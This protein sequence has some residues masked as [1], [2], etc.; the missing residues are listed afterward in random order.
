MPI[1]RMGNSANLNNGQP[2]PGNHITEAALPDGWD[3]EERWFNAIVDPQGIWR[4]HSG[5]S[6]P[7]WV[8]CSDSDLERRL[9]D[10]YGCPSGRPDDWEV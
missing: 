9:C 6:A 5:A 10:H 4:A 8:E 1:V 7:S 3:D 2:I